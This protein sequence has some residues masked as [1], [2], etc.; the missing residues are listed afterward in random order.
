MVPHIRK[1]PAITGT[2]FSHTEARRCTPPKKISPQMK[3]SAIPTIQDGNP[4]AVSNT[5]PIE[6]DCTMHPMNPSAKIM[7]TAKNPA[8]S[9]PKLPE[10]A[11]VI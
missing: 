2:I 4:N 9:L 10:N 7:A 3:D 8:K 11:A 6:L 1:S 5:E